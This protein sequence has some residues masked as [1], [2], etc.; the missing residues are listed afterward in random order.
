MFLPLS[1][2]TSKT[3]LKLHKLNKVSSSNSSEFLI[4]IVPPQNLCTATSMVLENT[5]EQK[6]YMIKKI[7]NYRRFYIHFG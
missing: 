3:R 7:G 5:E 6:I 4:K 2:T 1:K